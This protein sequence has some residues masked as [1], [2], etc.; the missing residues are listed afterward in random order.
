M[1]TLRGLGNDGPGRKNRVGAGVAQQ[2]EVLTRDHAADGDHRLV[3]TELA[4]RSF[5]RRDERKV[6][7][8]ERRDANDMGLLLGR[9]RGHLLR[10][11]KQRPDLDVEP[12]I[13]KRRGNDLLPAVMS[14]LAHLGDQNP[15]SATLVLGE[16]AGHRDHPLV[17]LSASARL[18]QIDAGNGPHFRNVTA[19][20]LLERQRDFADGG[21]RPRRFDRK[22]Q[23]IGPASRALGKR[24]Q[25]GLRRALVPLGAQALKLLDLPR[26]HCRCV[27]LQH[28]EIPLDR[29]GDRR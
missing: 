5:Q 8:G 4:Q 1:Q 23:Q 9:Q 22:L 27:N 6:A 10:S 25:R 19:E 13:R 16:G 17:G 29:R 2:G 7:R 26:A 14:I 11:C 28:A 24:R 21:L 15:G 3:K 18:G 20:S 12:E